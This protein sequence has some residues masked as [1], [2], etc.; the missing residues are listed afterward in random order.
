[1]CASRR[2]LS[3]VFLFSFLCYRGRAT[4][5]H[6]IH[7]CLPAPTQT[8]YIYLDYLLSQLCQLHTA[9]LNSTCARCKVSVLHHHAPALHHSQQPWLAAKPAP[10]HTHHPKLHPHSLRSSDGGRSGCSA[11]ASLPPLLSTHMFS[12]RVFAPSLILSMSSLP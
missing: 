7:H 5:E 8:T 4:D 12:A 6:F 10:H 9:L 11:P 2:Q 1:M 3:V